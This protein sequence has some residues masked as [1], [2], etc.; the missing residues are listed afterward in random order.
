MYK[1]KEILCKNKAN[2]Q[3]ALYKMFVSNGNRD[4]A[5]DHYQLS[6]EFYALSKEYSELT[7]VY[8]NVS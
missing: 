4:A 1:S 3:Y 8:Q 5:F 2:Y 7:M 6:Q